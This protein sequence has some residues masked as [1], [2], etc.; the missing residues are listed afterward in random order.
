VVDEHPHISAKGLDRSNGAAQ[1]TYSA[2]SLG[3]EAPE[4][5]TEGGSSSSG[6]T[7]A[8]AQRRQRSNP[9]RGSRGNKRKR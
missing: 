5:R 9:N 4:V 6:G 1:L 2:P 8:N 7:R 3:S